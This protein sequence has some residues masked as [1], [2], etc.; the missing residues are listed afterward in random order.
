MI[1]ALKAKLV[2]AKTL[3]MVASLLFLYNILA[4]SAL[5]T[6]CRIIKRLQICARPLMDKIETVVATILVAFST[7]EDLFVTF[8]DL[9]KQRSF[10]TLL[11]DPYIPHP[12]IC[13]NED[14]DFPFGVVGQFMVDA[15]P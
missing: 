14:I 8:V 13:I 7:L 4:F 12:I 1:A 15:I 10:V 11:A 3:D 9:L 5:A 2:P 6:T